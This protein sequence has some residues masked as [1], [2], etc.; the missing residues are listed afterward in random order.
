MK[1]FTFPGYGG[2]IAES[3][4]CIARYDMRN[5]QDYHVQPYT[6]LTTVI[7]LNVVGI[8]GYQADG[9]LPT[10]RENPML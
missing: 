5:C 3:S 7:L 1:V 6:M 9:R 4:S 8:C 2:G 10:E